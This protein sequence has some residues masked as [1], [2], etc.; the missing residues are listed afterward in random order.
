MI[1]SNRGKGPGHANTMCGSAQ[2]RQIAL[3]VHFALRRQD[4]LCGIL[5]IKCS[6][7]KKLYIFVFRQQLNIASFQKI[8]WCLSVPVYSRLRAAPIKRNP[9]HLHF[10]YTRFQRCDAPW[11]RESINI[12]IKHINC[13]SMSNIKYMSALYE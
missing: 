13:Y 8:L 10:L 3:N 12:H 1:R 4:Y 7:F 9:S 5:N 2:R 6:N 11:R